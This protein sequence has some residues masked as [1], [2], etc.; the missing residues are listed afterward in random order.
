M[1]S[2][3]AKMF[4]AKQ[5][6]PKAT[7]PHCL[8]LTLCA[9]VLLLNNIASSQATSSD[10]TLHQD[11]DFV[12]E[13]LLPI[14]RGDGDLLDT[15]AIA[16]EV[17]RVTIDQIN[18]NSKL[19]TNVK[20]G[21]DIVND[22]LDL[23]LIM[24]RAI[25]I[26]SKYRSG[27]ICRQ[28]EE[29]CTADQYSGIDKRVGAVIG[30]ATSSS[31]VPSA[32][33]LG[34]YNIPQISYSASSSI[35]SD[36]SR[37]KSFLRTIPSDEYQAKAIAS[38]VNYFDW[39]YVFFIGSDDEYGRQGL[40]EFKMA[41][42]KLKVCTADDVNIPFQR[43]NDATKQITKIIENMKSTP[44]VRVA[45]LF[46]FEQQASQVI[47]SSSLLNIRINVPVQCSIFS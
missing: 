35:L 2:K 8:S 24:K 5:R 33:L 23:H 28:D 13:V 11:G 29:F 16:S 42:R 39:N 38:F 10:S 45:V 47:L 41:G 1:K 40:A 4:S 26:V 9:F 34:L 37:F 46:M 18:N 14:T 19:L 44:R 31:S 36:T 12:M 32:S 7:F 21:Y 6:I 15:Y 25:G 22:K 17:V 20:L 27:S 3:V 30:P 43:P